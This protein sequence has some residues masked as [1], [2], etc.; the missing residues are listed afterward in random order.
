VNPL[1]VRSEKEDGGICPFCCTFNLP[2]IYSFIYFD[3]I[4]LFHGGYL[5]KTK[6]LM[7]TRFSVLKFEG[8]FT[9]AGSTLLTPPSDLRCRQEAQPVNQVKIQL[10]KRQSHD[11]KKLQKIKSHTNYLNKTKK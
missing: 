11:K 3:T 1:R 8:L 4:I 5:T 6:S 7:N 10:L 9:F 2:S